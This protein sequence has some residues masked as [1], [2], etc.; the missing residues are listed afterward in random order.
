MMKRIFTSA[1]ILLIAFAATAQTNYSSY[2]D[3]KIGEDGWGGCTPGPSRPFGMMKPGVNCGTDTGAMSSWLDFHLMGLYP[4][5]GQDLY[6]ICSPVLASSTMHL[7]GGDFTINAEK[8]SDKNRYIQSATLNGKPY[9]YSSLSHSDIA[10]SGTLVLKMGPR[11][12]DWGK[13]MK[14]HR[15]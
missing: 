15:Q 3:P 14:T 4:I 13:Q 8:L 1:I 6:L 11:P 2:V 12:S 10:S 5:A 9:P 7:P